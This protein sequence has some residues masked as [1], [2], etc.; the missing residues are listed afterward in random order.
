M[1]AAPVAKADSVSEFDAGKSIALIISTGVGGGV[2]TNAR[3]FARH[4]GNHIPGKPFIV[5]KNMTGAGHLQAT[6]YLYGPAVKDGTVIGAILP[7]FVG[8]QVL[9]GCG[10]QYDVRNFNFLGSSD[11]ENANL[12]TW[13]TLG[14]KE[15]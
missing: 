1:L 8:F 5:P 10:A 12:Y 9:D 11:V 13:H 4:L 15:D 14:I 3:L 7:T 2:D 6:N